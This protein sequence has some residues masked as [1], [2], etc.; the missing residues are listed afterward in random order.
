MDLREVLRVAKPSQMRGAILVPWPE[1]DALHAEAERLRALGERVMFALPGHDGTW[2][3]AGCDR[4][5]MRRNGEW[6]IEALKDV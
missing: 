1:D 2:T 6:I 4:Q 5:L 3:A